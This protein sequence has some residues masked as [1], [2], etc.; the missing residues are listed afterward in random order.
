M[1]R[2]ILFI[3]VFISL[4]IYS[5]NEKITNLDLFNGEMNYESKFE[6]KIIQL[7]N[8]NLLAVYILNGINVAYSNDNGKTWPNTTQIYENSQITNLQA[9]L[10]PNNEVLITYL[11]NNNKFK[12]IESSSN[13]SNWSS[14]NEI[15][16]ALGTEYGTQL[17]YDGDKTYL[18]FSRRS[19]IYYF[20]RESSGTWGAK[21]LFYSNENNLTSPSVI[22]IDSKYKLFFNEQSTDGWR[23]VSLENSI[24]S[25]TGWTNKKIIHSTNSKLKIPLTKVL[26]NQ[27]KLWISFELVKS[28][29]D[30][31]QNDIYYLTSNDNGENWSEATQFT[32][33]LRSDFHHDL[34]AVSN[35]VWL[36]FLSNR[37]IDSNEK[38]TTPNFPQLLYGI[39]GKS[40][41]FF[42][43]PFVEPLDVIF[44]DGEN[45][46]NMIFTVKAFDD[47]EL[48]EVKLVYYS[49]AE[50]LDDGMNNDFLANDS[51]YGI[52][53]E[54][55][56]IDREMIIRF[57]AT[58]NSGNEVYVNG[59]KYFFSAFEFDENAYLMRNNRSFLPIDRYGKIGDVYNAYGG[60]DGL[61]VLYSG[62]FA[63]SG[64][65]NRFIWAN[66]VVPSSR[67]EDYVAGTPD[68]A[69]SDPRAKMF[70]LKRSDPDF[71]ES[72]QKWTDAVQAGA[73]YYDGN[74]DGQYNPVDLNSNGKWDY[75]EDR[76]DLLGDKTIWSI[77]HDGVES[78][79]RRYTFIEPYGI[80]IKQTVFTFNELKDVYFLRY[81]IELDKNHYSEAGMYENTF[82]GFF[83]DPDLGEFRND[84]IFTDVEHQ[85]VG[86][87]NNGYD[88]IFGS[89]SPTSFTMLLQGPHAYIPGESFI[90]NNNN[91]KYDTGTDEVIDTA[92]YYYGE[93][94]GVKRIPGAKNLELHNSSAY[95]N[96]NSQ[97]GDPNK[98]EELGYLMRSKDNNGRATKSCEYP[99]G[100]FNSVDC[101][102]VDPHYIFSGDPVTDIGWIDNHPDDVRYLLN[103][104]PFNLDITESDGFDTR[105]SSFS[106]IGAIVFARGETQLNSIEIGRDKLD[107][108]KEF[109]ESN[110][111]YQIVGVNKNKKLPVKFVLE[112]NYPNPFNPA[113]TIKYSIP[114]NELVTLKVYDILG[115]EKV[116]LV[117]E[118]KSAGSYQLTFDGSDLTSGV[119]YYS[120]Q[121]GEYVETRKMILLK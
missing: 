119:Y 108:V 98:S 3:V 27:G 39:P 84:L 79:E 78:P 63:L 120:L 48:E 35:N 22:K 58:D 100:I 16:R 113:T 72:W 55:V 76:P 14:P 52:K 93:L 121:A 59:N 91:G 74:N 56:D 97:Y 80:I 4:N 10:Q 18:L 67:I 53:I 31:T 51:I 40:T 28:L 96:S 111:K 109:Y 75:N 82:F 41:D 77:M 5:Q 45:G 71:G 20:V 8:S 36:T 21:V 60:F 99:F 68:I 26:S 117:N 107:E 15:G 104:G 50:M 30:K 13:V 25:E 81:D 94:V 105:Q 112:Q 62:G 17:F 47:T 44:E 57:R 49:E 66:G 23:I 106:I 37:F 38:I 85:A 43:P 11:E 102:N 88:E 46:L 114:Q 64:D 69:L 90:D 9:M 29:L 34:I 12:Y 1:I 32:S 95:Y 54:D 86:V 116:E 87:Y 89:N 19:N 7:S 92:K 115:E 33:Y 61:S 24:I 110:F 70:L 101:K 2:K 83:L 73:N 118:I 65:P 103:V 42:T 6:V